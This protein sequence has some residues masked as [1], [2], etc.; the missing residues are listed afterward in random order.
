MRLQWIVLF[1]VLLDAALPRTFAAP[2]SRAT[3][4][5][6]RKFEYS[7]LHMGVQVRLVVHAPDEATA[8]R[9]GTAAF[10]RIAALEQILSDWRPDSEL[11]RLCRKAGGS[12]VRVSSELFFVLSCAQ[13]LSQRSGGAFDVSVGPYVALWRQ[14]RK[15][16]VFPSD[17]ELKSARV[18]VGWRKIQLDAKERRVRLTV[19]YMRLDL[20]GIAKGSAGDEALRVLK[21]HGITHVLFEAGGDIVTSGAPPQSSCWIIQVPANEK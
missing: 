5:I 6:L 18:R 17:Q 21:K 16:K 10:A 9:A 1:F 13:Q 14:A 12:W 19:P 15:T 20:G 3:P 4:N 2:A 8:M 11:M 7:Q